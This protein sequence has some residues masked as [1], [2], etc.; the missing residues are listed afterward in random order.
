MVPFS[1]ASRLKGAAA[2]EVV[3]EGEKAVLRSGRS[4]REYG[5]VMWRRLERMPLRLPR[6]GERPAGAESGGDDLAMEVESLAVGDW[7]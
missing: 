4:T 1:A 6:V 2:E 5:A 7:G 3:E